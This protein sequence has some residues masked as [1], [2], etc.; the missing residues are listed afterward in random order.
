MFVLINNNPDK[1]IDHTNYDR[2]V[3]LGYNPNKKLAENEVVVSELGDV[4]KFGESWLVST[5]GYNIYGVECHSKRDLEENYEKGMNQ[6]VLNEKNKPV[7]H[8]TETGEEL[9]F[10]PLGGHLEINIE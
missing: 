10:V 9:W 5:H 1:Q 2:V 7:Q 4:V 8:I 6:I 3:Y